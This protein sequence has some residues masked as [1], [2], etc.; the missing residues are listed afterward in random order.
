MLSE[1]NLIETYKEASY[2]FYSNQKNSNQKSKHWR[3]WYN[4]KDINLE[5][6]K[7]FRNSKSK[8]SGGLDLTSDNF[9]FKIYSNL[10]SKTSESYVLNN[11]PKQNIGNSDYVL[12]FKNVFVDSGK[13]INIY[14]FWLVENKILKNK[15]ISNICEIGG[16]FGSFSELFIRNYGT[17][18]FLIDLPEANL[19]SAYYLK[20]FFPKKN[21]IYLTIILKLDY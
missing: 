5:T 1:K 8:L 2:F 16:G 3:S 19:M 17:K 15:K 11:L 9:P 10:V 13:L 21:F 20:N 18:I 7:N 12:S 14:W 4:F 6:L